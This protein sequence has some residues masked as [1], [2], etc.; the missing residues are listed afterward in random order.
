MVQF[1]HL[2]TELG[3]R[4]TCTFQIGGRV[5]AGSRV[6]FPVSNYDSPTRNMQSAAHN[7]TQSQ[8]IKNIKQQI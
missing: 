8:K 7:M 3:Y 2:D 5:W 1:W 6:A 4:K